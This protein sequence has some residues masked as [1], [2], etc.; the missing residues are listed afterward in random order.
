MRIGKPGR[1]IEGAIPGRV[2]QEDAIDVAFQLDTAQISQD[3]TIS[4]Q[5]IGGAP[6]VFRAAIIG[7][8]IE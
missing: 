2:L 4:V 1:G 7:A 8:A 5:N 6:Q 3:V